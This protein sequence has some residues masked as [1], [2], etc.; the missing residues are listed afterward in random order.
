MQN[1]TPK[2]QLKNHHLKRRK[3]KE[4]NFTILTHLNIQ[5]LLLQ[6]IPM[7]E[8]R[9]I[10][11][12]RESGGS[13]HIGTTEDGAITDMFGLSGKLV[14][15][16][17][18]SIYELINAD[19]V[20]PNRENPDLPKD[21][22][23]KV[24]DLGSS[25]EIVCRTLITAKGLFKKY[26]IVGRVDIERVMML[27]LEGLQELVAMNTEI[28]EYL[29]TEQ[30]VCDEY[31][32]R[33]SK[34]MSYAIPSVHDINTR[35]KTIFQKADHVTQTLMEMAVLF[36][37]DAGLN[38]QSH[39]PKM[40][41]HLKNTYGEEDSFVTFLNSAID[42][43][44]TI[45]ALRNC[46]DHRLKEVTVTDFELQPNSDVLSPTIEINYRKVKLDRIS[47]NSYLPIAMANMITV[48]ESL[49]A[50]LSSKHINN[51]GL[52]EVRFI[53]EEQRRNKHIK[54]CYWSALGHYVH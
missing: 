46:L 10:D 19:D 35:C 16:K 15:V 4:R 1:L 5:V 30:K 50:Y 11:I 28:T 12:K 37:P 26:Y 38:K 32:D 13:A 21:I 23:R 33:R 45:R 34:K 22:Q 53:P 27:T 41:E 39:F 8:K 9:S 17:E 48:F 36:Y 44:D 24:L 47:L 20:D 42:F 25:S 49:I 2:L 40:L 51:D 3:I 6:I 7:K 18:N 31:E 14:I 29:E 43:L 52:H 54:Y